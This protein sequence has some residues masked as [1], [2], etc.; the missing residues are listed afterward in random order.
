MKILMLANARAVHTQRWATALA[1][2][3]HAITVASIRSAT[4]PNVDVVSYS[5]GNVD[6]V[7]LFAFVSYLRL[8]FSLPFLLR[9]LQ[10]DIV[11]PHYC[12]THG[13]IAALA[14]AQP[15]VVNVWGSDLLGNGEGPVS[16][17]RRGLIRLS[18]KQADAVISTSAFMADAVKSLLPN[19]PPIRLV[20]FGV[21]TDH[22]KPASTERTAGNIRIGYVKSFA[23][24]YAPDVFIEAASTVAKKRKEIDF[25]MAGRGPLLDQMRALADRK[26]LAGRISFTGFVPHDKVAETMR[27]LD[28]LVNCSRTESFGVVICE[29]SA[30]GLPVIATDVGGIREAMQGGKTGILVPRND[31]EALASAMIKLADDPDLRKR[32]GVAG[33]TFISTEYEWARCVDKME[34]ALRLETSANRPVSAA[35]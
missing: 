5:V 27:S 30:S 28:I 9:R 19:H 31:A 15:R 26:G 21:D 20:P 17:W 10:P 11:N 8:L 34:G 1:A 23:R 13:V 14:G 6:A 2:R 12:V 29:A 32:M 3:G 25:I 7:K 33:R 18:L 4:I 35:A 24:K 16:W 22:F